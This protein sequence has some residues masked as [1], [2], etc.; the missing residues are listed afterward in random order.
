MPLY[1][2]VVYRNGV[3]VCMLREERISGDVE[4][5]VG[6]MSPYKAAIRE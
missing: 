2:A 1:T 3:V 4:D 6:V 5:N